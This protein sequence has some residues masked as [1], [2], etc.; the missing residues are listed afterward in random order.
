MSPPPLRRV[1]LAGAAGGRTEPGSEGQ[2]GLI[3]DQLEKIIVKSIRKLTV[4]A[5]VSCVLCL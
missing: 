1:F 5:A 3:S 4:V 2:Y